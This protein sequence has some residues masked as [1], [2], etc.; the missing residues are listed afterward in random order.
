MAAE[1]ENPGT[2][3]I[4]ADGDSV[5]EMAENG[6]KGSLSL[7]CDGLECKSN[8]EKESKENYD[9]PPPNTL[10]PHGRFHVEFVSENPSDAPFGVNSTV[11][12]SKS[13]ESDGTPV[14]QK[15]PTS[16]RTWN[17]EDSMQMR[18]FGHNTHEA[19]PSLSFY[20]NVFSTGA[21]EGP[22]CRPTLQELHEEQDV[23]GLISEYQNSKVR[24]ESEIQSPSPQL[25]F[26]W[27]KGVLVRCLLN[28]W[29]VMLFL[30][31]SWVVGQAGIGLSIVIILLS[32]VVTVLTTLSMAAICTNGEVKGGGA[33]YMISRSLG[34]EFGGAI[35]LIFSLANAVAVAMYVV[36]F[37]ETVRDL[38]KE[39]NVKIVDDIND[40]RIIG[41]ITVVL[42]LGV[43]LV[44]MAWEARAQLVLLVILIL[45][46]VD[47]VIGTF[48]P[49]SDQEIGKGF[50]GYK[51]TLFVENGKPSYTDGHQFFSVFAIFF[52]AATG[53]LAGAN[54]SGDLADAQSAIPKGTLL[55]ILISTT[56]YVGMAVMLGSCVIREAT[57]YIEDM[58]S[59]NF[60]TLCS[61]ETCDYGLL[62]DMQ[63]VC[64]D[65]IFPK[66]YYF[67]HG[68]GPSNEPRRAYILT[69]FIAVI[70]ILIGELN[71]IAP[72]I[73]GFFLMSYAL[74]N[75]SCFSASL[76]RP[77]GWRP[78]FRF[79]N[80][81][82]A[83]LA[84]LL[85]LSV[86]FM[87]NWWAALL[88][89]VIVG[90][91]YLYVNHKKPEINW[92]SSTQAFI[93]TQ[94]LQ[95]TLKLDNIPQHV[96]NFRPQC[97][98]LSGAPNCRPA[99]VYFVNHL[100][101]NTSLMIC[102]HVL[103]GEQKQH[104]PQLMSEYQSSWL[105]RERIKGFYACTCAPTL[106]SGVEALMQISGIGKFRPNTV[107]LGYKNNWRTDDAVSVE[108]YV[109]IIHS[110]FDISYGVCILRLKEGLDISSALERTEGL[111]E[112]PESIKDTVKE[113]LL[114]DGDTQCEDSEDEQQKHTTNKL[115][116]STKLVKG[117]PIKDVIK[118]LKMFQE[119]QGKGTID[120][121][122]L[123]DDG[124]LTLLVPHI[125]SMKSQWGNCKL[126]VFTSGK[127]DQIDR[128]RMSMASM[129]NKFRID[130]SAV[131]IL[132]DINKKPQKES[133]RRF[134]ELIEPYMLNHEEKEEDFPWKI[135]HASLQSFKD[136][137]NRQIRLGELLHQHSKDAKLI[138]MSLPMPRKK[139]V[140]S[141]LY[142]SWLETLS[143]DLPPI[144][145]MRGNQ[146]S[147]LTFYS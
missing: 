138:V 20:R 126:R 26:G 17:G 84:S 128:D 111:D 48:I 74:I 133:I 110:A 67:A 68:S 88:T 108:E 134:E 42:L 141:Y 123:F 82:M 131:E 5:C 130:Y 137:T 140:S 3:N 109:N 50:I 85:C 22:R 119:K 51:G 92:G 77:P 65:K 34:P 146:T 112:K 16:P 115:S 86:M 23:T 27:I 43:A 24:E 102:G 90:A 47:F 83:L 72:I 94:S 136:K 106:L 87:I 116:S 11:T 144:L 38:M 100:T 56:V 145:L 104:L 122:W 114:N 19:V 80:M 143:K 10:K 95:S 62:N 59:G 64:K 91:L 101:K 97:L 6:E 7:D 70:F 66:I 99:L 93:Y 81:W 129:L 125:I 12:T 127:A 9:N 18:T 4:G 2:L 75:F 37:A 105:K 29:G 30:R 69:F 36:G 135:T 31:L 39:H 107:F 132:P 103:K 120:V 14:S 13:P 15:T 58:V 21:G 32:A 44:G 28:I 1:L 113:K 79:Y 49:P 78:G 45:A 71:A 8:T 117:E 61:N 147:V 54:I 139:T 121:W 53:I 142:M 89:I 41:I 25:K 96:K 124:G 60:T 57:G 76:A 35:G 63:A 46:I 52:P 73:S 118:T 40:I 33:Y 98:V 55:A